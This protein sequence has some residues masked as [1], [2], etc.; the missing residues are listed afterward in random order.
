MQ[1]KYPTSARTRTKTRAKLTTTGRRHK[2]KGQEHKHNSITDRSNG[3]VGRTKIMTKTNTRTE[4]TR[5]KRKWTKMTKP[6]KRSEHCKGE[7]KNYDED[8]NVAFVFLLS[9]RVL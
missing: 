4:L 8:Q 1:F 7:G 9:V 3:K 6:A 5:T 2:I